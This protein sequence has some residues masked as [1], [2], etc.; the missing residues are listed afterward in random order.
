MR[1]AEAAYPYFFPK[2]QTYSFGNEK[3]V[4]LGRL[5]MPISQDTY[6]FYS[7]V[8]F[9]S[10]GIYTL[11]VNREGTGAYTTSTYSSPEVCTGRQT[12]CEIG[13]A[14]FFAS[15]KGLLTLTPED[16]GKLYSAHINGNVCLLPN[17]NN[18]Y[19]Y[20]LEASN[21]VA[22][23]T[24]L[25]TEF[26]SLEDFVEFLN[27][28]NTCVRYVS[29][30][31]KLVIYNRDFG[32]V[33]FIDIPTGNTTKLPMRID[34]DNGDFPDKV[35]WTQH[36]DNNTRYLEKH[37]FG[38]TSDDVPV[39]CLIQ[40]RPIVVQADDKNSYRFVITGKFEGPDDRWAELVSLGSLDAEH[41][42]VLGFKEKRLSGGGFH[43]LGCTTERD[44]W[45]Y[46]MFIFAGR[47]NKN[48]HIDSIDMTVQG[49]YN[50]KKR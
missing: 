39:S 9:C 26:V 37:V 24:H 50:N 43:N 29:N 33:Y 13:G 41:W 34:F 31:N 6:G 15:D 38:Y 40:S 11:G 10:D 19:K 46:L 32:Y 18:V 30:K 8:V 4:G 3:I 49:R 16:T 2:A 27:H 14:L 1:V 23:D 45:K 17:D 28:A 5:T 35:F 22:F 47:L 25:Y 7:L 42:H 48:S 21:I 20:I 12:I 36:A 44:S